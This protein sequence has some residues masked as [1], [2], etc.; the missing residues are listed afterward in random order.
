MSRGA[1]VLDLR[2]PLRCDGCG[3]GGGLPK[4]S[5]TGRALRWRL[6]KT[7][8]PGVDIISGA[9]LARRKVN[10]SPVSRQNAVLAPHCKIF[11]P[12]R[13]S[14]VRS[15]SSEMVLP[16]PGT[17]ENRRPGLAEHRIA[18][19]P[20]RKLRTPKAVRSSLAAGGKRIRTT[21]PAP[22]I[23]VQIAVTNPPA[24]PRRRTGRDA[25][26]VA[27]SFARVLTLSAQLSAALRPQALRPIGSPASR[28]SAVQPDPPRTA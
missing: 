3:R 20:C 17:V 10:L 22:T 16:G 2:E 13:R 26:G 28:A 19:G 1:K 21:G 7:P 5:Q 24:P 4:W 15:F 18:R 6:L 12:C 23:G 8:L 11:V 14:L 9:S 27:P 25:A